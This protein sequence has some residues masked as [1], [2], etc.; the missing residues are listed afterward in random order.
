M[1]ERGGRAA[2]GQGRTGPDKWLAA[3]EGTV[4][5][6]DEQGRW[7]LDNVPPGN[8]LDL[9]LKL[10]HPDYISDPNWGTSQEEQGID[11]K[12]LRARTATITMRGGLVATGTVTDAAGKPIAGA[13]VVRGD[14]PYWEEGSQEVRTDEHGRYRLPPLPSGQ[15]NVT[16]MATG[17]MP[18]ITKVDIR[19]G[20]SPF[21]FRLRPGNDLQIR[22]VDQAG[23]PIPGV[24]VAIDKWRGGESLYN[25][26]HPNV[27]DAGIPRFADDKGLFHWT[28]APDEAVNYTLFKEGYV[29]HEVALTASA[30]EQT[31]TL[32]KI[33]RISGKVTDTAGLPIKGVTAIPVIEFRPGHLIV[34]R[35]EAKGPFDGTYTIAG[36]RTDV[37]YRVRIEAMGYRTVMSDT[38]RAG[39]LDP[40]FD[41][42]LVSAPPLEGQIV[43]S[44]GQ[45]AIGARVY[46]GHT[47]SESQRLAER[48]KNRLERVRRSCPM[49]RA[50]SRSPPNSNAMRLWPCMTT[51]MPRCNSNLAS[52][53]VN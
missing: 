10:S 40:T 14:H 4:P 20:M 7:T 33:L 44:G 43:D 42:R 21:D 6:T 26:K 30:S 41:F 48:P 27:L 17:W 47:L 5:V 9:R 49:A 15:V 3:D 18:A 31:V 46:L 32:P 13:I 50:D 8:D 28:W 1:L 12:A 34:E 23:T 22:I 39:A 19:Q 2:D 38:V 36:D 24:E 16:V 52:S 25:H 51:A 53:P 45:A 29:R 37:S 11:L 35:N